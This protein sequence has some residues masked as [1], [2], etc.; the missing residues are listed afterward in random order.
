MT[1]RRH[2]LRHT[3][4]L[5]PPLVATTMVASKA[6]EQVA[7]SALPCHVDSWIICPRVRPCSRGGAEQRVALR[8][9]CWRSA[10]AAQS[11]SAWIAA[12]SS[13]GGPKSFLSCC[14]YTLCRAA[15]HPGPATR[16]GTCCARQAW[17]GRLSRWGFSVIIAVL[18]IE[19]EDVLL[20]NACV[21][22]WSVVVRQLTGVSA[23]K[24]EYSGSNS[25][26]RRFSRSMLA[27][28]AVQVYSSS[29]LL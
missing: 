18:W 16:L 4:S 21:S 14:L 11:R 9:A 3:S 22:L 2:R 12:A 19:R 20:L 25:P 29:M 6:G 17:D 27:E 5:L 23:L 8:A 13:R 1:S 28:S 15:T 24:T 7:A 10:Y 26:E